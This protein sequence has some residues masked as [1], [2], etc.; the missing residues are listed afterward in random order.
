MMSKLKVCTQCGKSM[1][2]V[3]LKKCKLDSMAWYGKIMFLIQLIS[4]CDVHIK[5][6]PT[7]IK[8][9]KTN[10]S[11]TIIWKLFSF[12]HCS[13]VKHDLRQDD[14]P[15]ESPDYPHFFTSK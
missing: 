11:E 5:G 4:Q 14:F 15:R 9:L 12:P 3:Q 10:W 1:F 2:L 13:L 8:Y 7:W 6:F